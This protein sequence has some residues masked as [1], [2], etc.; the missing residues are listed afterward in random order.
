M[1]ESITFLKRLPDVRSAVFLLSMMC[2]A[3][4]IVLMNLAYIQAKTQL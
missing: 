1:I 3:G 4:G 2:E